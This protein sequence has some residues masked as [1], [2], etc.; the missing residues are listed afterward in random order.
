L[1]TSSPSSETTTTLD[2]E[3]NEAILGC[4]KRR[5]QVLS[6]KSYVQFTPEAINE[7]EI[8][9]ESQ[10]DQADVNEDESD[11][12]AGE[13]DAEETESSS[14]SGEEG[15]AD[16]SEA[17]SH[18]A[19]FS[20][21]ESVI[22]DAPPSSLKRKRI[23]QPPLPERSVKKKVSFAP[24]TAGKKGTID[25]QTKPSKS[26]LKPQAASNGKKAVKAKSVAK[27]PASA[28]KP[29]TARV[30]N[31]PKSGKGQ[32]QGEEAYDFSRFF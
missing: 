18:E 23:E 20:E 2:K 15:D 5:K 22:E 29:S 19:E 6:T 17:E 7:F 4:L 30:G 8:V 12:S 27:K 10:D 13:R 26:A 28:V 32:N 31:V 24:R 3:I 11:G 9:L 21:S 16:A 25:G 1:P 14:D